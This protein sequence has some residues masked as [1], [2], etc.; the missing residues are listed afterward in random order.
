M[1]QT[2]R[3][4]GHEL[5][6]ALGGILVGA[7]LGERRP[8]SDADTGT[9]AEIVAGARR[10]ADLMKALRPWI[11][12]PERAEADVERDAAYVEGLSPAMAPLL[13]QTKARCEEEGIP[14]LDA[15]SARLLSL[16]VTI[17]KPKAILELGTANGYSA[18]WMA[19]AQ[20]RGG[21]IVTVE[22]DGVRA[23][24]ARSLFGAAGVAEQIDVVEGR[25]L[26]VIARL[27]DRR[28]GLVF[29]DAVK[30][31]YAQ[32]LDAVMPLLDVGGI[33]VADNLLWSSRASLPPSADDASATA[34]IRRFNAKFLS[35][36]SLRAVILPVGDGV[37]VGVKTG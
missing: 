12:A 4:I 21:K 23:A 14:L 26:E 37:G 13:A 32:Y 34:G 28:F 36:P 9:F 18:L 25:A 24:A 27:G 22:L 5:A 15:P 7:E 35:H 3:E 31:E 17:A 2:G 1:T 11:A 33:V 29:I 16:L 30:E 20:G 6:N 10:A 19:L 8:R